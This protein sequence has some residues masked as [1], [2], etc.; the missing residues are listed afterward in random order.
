MNLRPLLPASYRFCVSFF[1]LL[2]RAAENAE[3]LILAHYHKLF[4]IELDLRASVF[5]KENSISLFYVEGTDLA[6]VSDFALPN[7]DDFAFG[8]YRSPYRESRCRR[9]SSPPARHGG[10]PGQQVVFSPYVV[11]NGFVHVVSRNTQRAGVHDFVA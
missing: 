4:A 5:A 10:L 1:L 9:G 3:H 11:G 2:S 7:S 6:V 8:A